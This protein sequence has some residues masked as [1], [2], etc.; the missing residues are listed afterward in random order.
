MGKGFHSSSDRQIGSAG[1]VAALLIMLVAANYPV[2]AYPQDEEQAK[3]T[4]VPQEVR[5]T[6]S[7]VLPAQ[8]PPS[9]STVPTKRR[10]HSVQSADQSGA[11][12]VEKTIRGVRPRQPLPGGESARAALKRETGRK[13]AFLFHATEG[14]GGWEVYTNITVPDTEDGLP[15]PD[16]TYE[17]KG[18]EYPE[19]GIT[20]PAQVGVVRKARYEPG[21]RR[22]FIATRMEKVGVKGSGVGEPGVGSAGIGAV[23]ARTTEAPPASNVEPVPDAV[24]TNLE[25]KGWER[26]KDGSGWTHSKLS[27]GKIPWQEADRLQK[28][29]DD[30]G[31]RQ[32]IGL[33]ILAVMVVLVGGLVALDAGR[34]KQDA[35]RRRQEEI[36]KREQDEAERKRLEVLIRDA[37]GSAVR[38]D[39][40]EP[41]GAGHTV[42]P[43]MGQGND[44]Q[45]GFLFKITLPPGAPNNAV[46]REGGVQSEK[47]KAL[48]VYPDR[49][50]DAKSGNYRIVI[51]RASARDGLFMP[52]SLLVHTVR[53]S[54]DWRNNGYIEV[55]PAG[56]R[57]WVT[58]LADGHTHFSLAVN[59]RALG[60]NETCELLKGDRLTIG[61]APSRP[62]SFVDNSYSIDMELTRTTVPPTEPPTVFIG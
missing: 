40:T 8:P 48:T 16:R 58:N 15:E 51:R 21:M 10:T 30:D 22:L 32:T 14:G 9:A 50:R 18:Y 2:M 17:I 44:L 59:G 56:Q 57:C 3:D 7:R 55:D 36:R 37:A 47:M 38:S 20:D 35:E 25:Q 61:L 24:G 49:D 39:G 11:K 52:G 41:P 31:M 33:G 5:Q 1:K 42:A 60:L 43:E 28:K 54:R 27:A 13:R 34:R 23:S 29:A 46:D 6:T 4:A 53:A 12:A 26:S 19:V 45:L 62:E